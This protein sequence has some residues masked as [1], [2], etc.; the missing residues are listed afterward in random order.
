MVSSFLSRFLSYR[1]SFGFLQEQLI[2]KIYFMRTSDFLKLEFPRISIKNNW[3]FAE[4]PKF[5]ILKCCERRDEMSEKLKIQALR[6]LHGDL[7]VVN[8]IDTIYK[9]R[10]AIKVLVSRD[11]K[12]AAK[13]KRIYNHDK[14]IKTDNSLP[15]QNPFFEFLHHDQLFMLNTKLQ[16]WNLK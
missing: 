3:A 13:I 8:L 6:K 4:F 12:M 7:D 9:L 14:L 16:Q 2:R 1:I 10:A 11:S 15:L 5:R